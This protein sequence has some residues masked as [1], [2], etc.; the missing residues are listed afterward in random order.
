M[1]PFSQDVLSQPTGSRVE[2]EML[3]LLGRQASQMFQQNGTPLNQAIRELAAQHPELGNEHIKRVVEFANNVTFQEMFQGGTDKNV[4]FEVADPGVILRDLKDGGSPAHSGTTMD[5]DYRTA[6]KQDANAQDASFLDQQIWPQGG[7]EGG[8]GALKM[9]SANA[10]IDELHDTRLQLQG[11]LEKLAESYELAGYELDAAK[12]SL[13]SAVRHEILSPHGA[14]LGGVVGAL[15]KLAH[16][17]IIAQII[18]PM[19]ERMKEEGFQAKQLESSLEKRAGMSVNPNHPLVLSFNEIIKIAN[20]M[21]VLD[22]AM[23]EAD[24]ALGSVKADLKKLAGPVTS[25]VRDAVNHVGK[26]PPGIRQRFPRT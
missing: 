16:E 2:P 3:E 18:P 14:G 6:P 23:S 25:A 13:Y 20:E 22:T 8:A 7:S 21:V 10:S 11:T 26:L 19:I 17:D 12:D 9:A 4:H 1:D 15:T 24:M 5:G